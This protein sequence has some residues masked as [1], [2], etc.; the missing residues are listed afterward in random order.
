M[1]VPND[2]LKSETTKNGVHSIL[3]IKI[4]RVMTKNANFGFLMSK[5]EKCAFYQNLFELKCLYFIILR[6]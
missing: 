4:G 5:G 6:N 3:K 2:F 1:L